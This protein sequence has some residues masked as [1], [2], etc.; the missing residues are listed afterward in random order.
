MGGIKLYCLKLFKPVM[1]LDVSL[2]IF[3]KRIIAAKC[4][5]EGADFLVAPVALAIGD[6]KL[7]LGSAN[8]S[9]GYLWKKSRGWHALLQSM[10]YF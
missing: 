4:R 6:G 1:K 10:A 5:R 9:S 3:I 7:A 2:G 8:W